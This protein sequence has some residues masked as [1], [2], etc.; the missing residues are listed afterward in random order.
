MFVMIILI[1]CCGFLIYY[2]NS[3]EDLEAIKEQINNIEEEITLERNKNQELIGKLEFLN[4]EKELLESANE[5]SEAKNKEIEELSNEYKKQNEELQQE[6]KKVKKEL[7]KAIYKS[8]TNTDKVKEQPPVSEP[9]VEKENEDIDKIA[10]LTFDDGPSNN[11]IKILDILKDYEAK[12]TFFTLGISASSRQD[13]I[14]RILDEGHAIGNHTYSHDYEQIYS[15]VDAFF[16]DLNK[17]EELLFKISGIK[18][19][20]IRFPG[21]SNNQVSWGYGG[22]NI[23]SEIINTLDED[24][25]QYFDWNVSSTDASVR[26]QTK[27]K[28][29]ESVINGSKG[30][31]KIIVLF[32]DTAIKTTTVEALPEILTELKSMGF[33]FEVLTKDSYAPHFQ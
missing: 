29:I 4:N 33:N 31:S 24:K 3:T 11:T 26:L 1:L 27:E 18:P 20:I 23:M 17:S 10:Y 8:K 13:I 2:F 25:Y 7:E 21:G 22:K 12:A 19:N 30:K 9:V 5:I 32:H 28:I 14:K 16:Q 6:I 15:S